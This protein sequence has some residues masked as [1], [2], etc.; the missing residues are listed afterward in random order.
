MSDISALVNSIMEKMMEIYSNSNS[1]HGDLGRFESIETNNK[2]MKLY[3]YLPRSKLDLKLIV[4][5][6][7]EWNTA[8]PPSLTEEAA[9]KARRS[10]QMDE[11]RHQARQ[12]ME[13]KQSSEGVV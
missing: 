1:L 9:E 3:H 2:G 13:S 5:K 7:D 6:W 12:K 4:R 10:A 8:K 11:L